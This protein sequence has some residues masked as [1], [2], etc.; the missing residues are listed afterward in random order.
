MEGRGANF[1]FAW[2]CFHRGF[3]FSFSSPS[4]SLEQAK[5]TVES[6][7]TFL[8][9]LPSLLGFHLHNGWEYFALG[10]GCRFGHH[11]HTVSE[12]HLLHG[13]VVPAVVCPW[14]GAFFRLPQLGWTDPGQFPQSLLAW[15]RPCS[16]WLSCGEYML[17]DL[18]Y[19][20]LIPKITSF[21]TSQFWFLFLHFILI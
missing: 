13:V 8:C 2:F 12:R 11:Y 5:E 14:C 18:R 10:A 1:N 4:E 9:T 15:T 20:S 7:A 3:I 19:W 16:A 17:K 6:C 21:V